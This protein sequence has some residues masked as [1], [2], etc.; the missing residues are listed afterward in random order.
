MKLRV[1]RCFRAPRGMPKIAARTD[2][3][4]FNCTD[5]RQRVR[6]DRRQNNC[7]DTR[8]TDR[9]DPRQKACTDER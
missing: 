5:K 9:T 2:P 3:R 6:T 7:T 1:C 4:Q 8:K